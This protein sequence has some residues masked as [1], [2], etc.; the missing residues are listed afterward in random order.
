MSNNKNTGKKAFKAE[1]D[2]SKNKK[3]IVTHVDA[4]KM[5]A[6]GLHKADK[7]KMNMR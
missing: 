6:K 1:N 2:Y 5:I 7:N 4:L 3:G